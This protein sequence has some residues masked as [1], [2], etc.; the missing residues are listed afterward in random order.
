MS[1]TDQHEIDRKKSAAIPTVS[2]ID[3]DGTLIEI[4][5]RLDE[6]KTLFAVFQNGIARTEVEFVTSA[7]EHLVPFSPRNNV[8]RHR[9]ALLRSEIA[10]Y[11]S[12][13]EL[14][15]EIMRFLHRYP[16]VSAAFELIAAHYVLFTWVYDAFQEIPYLRLQGDFGSGESRGL[17]T[18]G[19]L[20]YKGFFASGA[21]TVSPL[22]HILDAFRG[23][24]ILDET[25]F[26]FSDEQAEISKV[27]NNGNVAGFPVLRTMMNRN[28]EFDPQAFQ[29]FSPKIVA[30]RGAYQDR[31]LESRFLTEVMGTSKLRPEIPINLNATL[32]EEAQALRKKL[33]MFRFRH[34]QSA[35]LTLSPLDRSL[36]PRLRQILSPLL[37]LVDDP[38]AR[39]AILSNVSSNFDSL[40]AAR[41]ESTEAQLLAIIHHPGTR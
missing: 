1:S 7:G 17:L 11:G 15:A 24:L 36:P 27:L 30:M 18:I 25:D 31:A 10:E 9:V 14:L 41:T 16:D 2:H 5:Y 22:F 38:A 35:T 12:K 3:P 29:V 39:A 32:K 19:S 8:I 13:E 28:K 34:R 33:V 23:T 21:S 40:I 4:L 20:C 6:A 37:A 26:R